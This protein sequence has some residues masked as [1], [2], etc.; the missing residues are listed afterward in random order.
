MWIN[1]F[2]VTKE[3]TSMKK[4]VIMIAGLMVIGI[5]VGTGCTTVIKYDLKD[6]HM[7]R[8][9]S[10]RQGMR[11]AVAPLQ[12]MRPEQ[13][14]DHP[15]G[16]YMSKIETRDKMFKD[17]DVPRGISEAL[18]THF[19]HI[20]LF[21]TAEMVDKSAAVPTA[22][23][24]EEMKNLNYDALFTGKVKHFYGAGYPTVFDMV[25][26]QLA[27]IPI[28][29]LVTIPTMLIQE[30]QNEGYVEIIDVQLT[31]TTSG[32]VLWSGSFSKKME[33]KYADVYP[34]RAAGETLKE[35][36]NEIVKQIES[37]NIN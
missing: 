29:A 19:N 25:A 14:K 7:A 2:Y 17:G 26:I 36:A 5:S 16:M 9:D 33:M 21:K 15:V 37:V 27:M 31:D 12:D 24:V 22:D 10:K 32:D 1:I 23:V 11:V 35:I 28:T 4:R 30:N 34:A 3:R 18:I 6:A 20:Q 13:E 8:P